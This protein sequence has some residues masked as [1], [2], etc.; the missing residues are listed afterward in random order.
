MTRVHYFPAG[1]QRRPSGGKGVWRHQVGGGGNR[2]LRGGVRH[3]DLPW[4]VH[5]RARL[6]PVDRCQDWLCVLHLKPRGTTLPFLTKPVLDA[7][8]ARTQMQ[9]FFQRVFSA[10]F[11][12]MNKQYNMNLLST[13]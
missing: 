13:I 3:A 8:I 5:A 4:G 7:S 1:G 10:K 11:L 12:F 2:Q 9:L 6:R